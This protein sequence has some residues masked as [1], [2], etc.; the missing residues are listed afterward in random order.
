MEPKGL[1]MVHDNRMV[2]ECTAV[3]GMKTWSGIEPEPLLPVDTKILIDTSG[4][5]HVSCYDIFHQTEDILMV[6]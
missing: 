2:N 1:Y 3:G 5:Q 4:A 6:G